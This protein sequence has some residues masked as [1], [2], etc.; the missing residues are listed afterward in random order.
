MGIKVNPDLRRVLDNPSRDFHSIAQVPFPQTLGVT[1]K[2]S[3]RGPYLYDNPKTPT[4]RSSTE[5]T[6]IGSTRLSTGG[7]KRVDSEELSQKVRQFAKGEI[8]Q[9]DFRGYLERRDVE[10][11]PEMS[12]YIKLHAETQSVPYNTLGRVFLS[13]LD[14]K[15]QSIDSSYRLNSNRPTATTAQTREQMKQELLRQE[16]DKLGN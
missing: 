4:V 12:R 8:T 16:L 7:R 15:S 13:S 10:V 1:L 5:L 11:T 6:T 9:G 3:E 2:S 14:P